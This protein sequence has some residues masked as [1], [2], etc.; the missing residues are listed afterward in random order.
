MKANNY[1]ELKLWCRKRQIQKKWNERKRKRYYA[2]ID[3]Y[4]QEWFI[5]PTDFISSLY[6][7]KSMGYSLGIPAKLIGSQENYLELPKHF[8]VLYRSDE[9]TATAN[10][11]LKKWGYDVTI[12]NSGKVI[13]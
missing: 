8:S 6:I 2:D 1:E 10:S 13:S 5:P 4:R 3:K 7:W 12:N 11:L 9:V